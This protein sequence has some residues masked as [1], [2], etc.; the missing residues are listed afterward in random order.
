MAGTT[1]CDHHDDM[2]AEKLVAQG[3]KT[4]AIDMRYDRV[5]EVDDCGSDL[6]TQN[7]AR[8]M[9]HGWGVPIAQHFIKSVIEAH[10]GRKVSLVD[11][12][13]EWRAEGFP[14]SQSVNREQK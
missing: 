14:I 3:V 1:A 10:P 11:G 6:A 13:P 12:F 2:L 8:N 9:D 4:Y 7:P 5:C